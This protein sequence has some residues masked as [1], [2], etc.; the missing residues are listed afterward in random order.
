MGLKEKIKEFISGDDEE[1]DIEDDLESVKSKY[2]QPAKPINT[3]FDA[4]MVLYEPRSYDEAQDTADCLKD[5]KA[6]LINLHRL[7]PDFAQRTIDFL[8]G[9]VYALDG[10][11]QK[12]GPNIILC[13]PKTIDVNG[14]IELTD[15]QE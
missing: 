14:T 11:I 9:V 6:C 2:E 4:T 8:T 5:S 15:V 13:T 12:V 3:H 1:F 10:K 7:N